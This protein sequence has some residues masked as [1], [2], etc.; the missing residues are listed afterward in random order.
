MRKE[1]VALGDLNLDI[2]FSGL[3]SLPRPGHEVLSGRCD[4]KPGGSCANTAMVLKAMGWPVCL[5]SLLGDDRAGEDVLLGLSALGLDTTTIARAAGAS[6]G[7]TVVMNAPEDRAYV[8]ASGT[9][10]LLTRKDLRAGYLRTGGH[11][12][13]ASF[14]LQRALQP[15]IGPLLREAKEAEMSTSLDPGHDPRGLWDLEFLAPFFQYLDWFMPNAQEL[16]AMAGEGDIEQAFRRFAPDVRG[17]VTKNGSSGASLC[18][19]GHVRHYPA[20]SA[21]VLDRSCAGDSFNAGFLS[22]IYGGL[23][24]ER[25]VEL[26]NALGAL[27][28][29]SV[30][31]PSA[32]HV[33]ST[34]AHIA[35]RRG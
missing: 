6:T 26:G 20:L 17:I 29:S 21:Q 11:L 35:S 16:M 5:Y 7:M 28:V 12:H 3:Q 4:M 18:V 24:L 33:R 14:F 32:E 10:D 2:V 13:L 19:D 34:V 8:T 30:G 27:A 31:L 1:I 23:P 15:E 25:A 9:V 22:G